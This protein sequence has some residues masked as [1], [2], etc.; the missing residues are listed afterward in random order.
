MVWWRASVALILAATVLLP[1]AMP[2]VELIG[3][4]EG[5]QAWKESERLLS[6]SVNTAALVAGTLALALPVGIVAAVLL[7]RT[8][9]PLRHLVRFLTLLTL[10][11]PLPLVASAWQAALGTGGWLPVAVW[12]TPPPGDPDISVTG[13]AWKP[14]AHGL[15]AA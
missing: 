1:A 2:F 6:L 9:F 7:Y 3:R 13:I 14:W 5:W 8:D 12:N 4:P 15:G 10:F 11:I